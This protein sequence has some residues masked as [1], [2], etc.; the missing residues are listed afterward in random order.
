MTE[1]RPDELPPPAWNATARDYPV[2]LLH[3]AFEAQVARTP[4]APAIS[5]RDESLSYRELNGR[6][7]PLARYLVELRRRP[8]TSLVGVCMERSL[9]MV[10]ALYGDAQGRRRRTCPSTPSTRRPAGLHARGHAAPDPAHPARTS[11]A[12]CPGSAAQVVPPRTAWP[13]HRRRERPSV[14]RRGGIAR[15]PRLRHLHLGLD[16]PA[17]GRD[18][19]PPRHPQPPALDAGGLSGSTPADRVLQKTPFSFDVSVWE[20]FWPLMFGAGSSSREPGGHRDRA[21]LAQADRR[22]RDHHAALR[23]V[24]AAAL[25]GGAAWPALRVACGAS[26]AAARRCP[27]ALRGPLL[28]AAAGAELHNLY[29]PT[30]AA[31]DVTAWACEPR[32]TGRLV[33]IGRP[34]A[35]TQIYLLDARPAAG[36]DRASPG[37]LYIGGVQVGARLPRP[38][39]S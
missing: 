19:R 37:E 26:S 10:V 34:I 12:V 38:A 29:G 5:F 27:P 21:Y 1:L 23:A 20:F 30:E 9:E 32:A 11:R 8:R 17:Q 25:P 2:A 22:A 3:E 39:R 15:R 4:E 18:E 6:A 13:T 16:R 31:V 14:R 35:N 24:D 33:P 7:N 28:R 36:A